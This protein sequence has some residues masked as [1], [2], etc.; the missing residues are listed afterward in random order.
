MRKI[1]REAVEALLDGRTY[2]NSNTTVTVEGPFATML[3]HG[4]AIAVHNTKTCRT[5]ICTK[6]YATTTTKERLNGLPGVQVFTHK[7]VLHLNGEPWEEH[8]RWTSPDAD[9]ARAVRQ[10]R[11]MGIR[12]E[13]E[14]LTMLDGA[15]LQVALDRAGHGEPGADAAPG[16]QISHG[17]VRVDWDRVAA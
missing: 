15:T 2:N 14:V 17:A 8:H 7:H 9:V 5:A 3:L 16:V 6:G 10:A 12:V 13:P 11:A 4:N 1:T